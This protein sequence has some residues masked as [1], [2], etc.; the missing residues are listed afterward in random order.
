MAKSRKRAATPKAAKAAPP[1]AVQVQTA[2]AKAGDAKRVLHVMN[3]GQPHWPLHHR[4]AKGEWFELRVLIDMQRVAAGGSAFLAELK[5]LPDGCMQAVVLSQIIE[6]L[7]APQV[8]L[9]LGEVLRILAPQGECMCSLPDA[10]MLA[11]FVASG[12][13]S[14]TI[15]MQQDVA[16][17]PMDLLFGS[18][19]SEAQAHR[20]AWSAADFAQQLQ[21]AGFGAIDITR[22]WIELW[23]LCVK[24]P[25]KA[26]PPRIRLDMS[27]PKA[28]YPPPPPHTQFNHAGQFAAGKLSDD[29][30]LPPNA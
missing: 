13:Q 3:A 29:L 12:Q 17:T 28:V 9:L 16:I 10:Q 4:Y 20:S 25:A 14:R 1:L 30:D 11:S 15:L 18:G 5:A 2:L 22:R 24:Q 21:Q 19:A 27:Y 8:A 23:C 6:R 7:Y 26:V